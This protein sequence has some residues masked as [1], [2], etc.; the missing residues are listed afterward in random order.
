MHMNF[1]IAGQSHSFCMLLLADS[2]GKCCKKSLQA[3]TGQV[4]NLGVLN[5]QE[6]KE[7]HDYFPLGRRNFF[8]SVT[9]ASS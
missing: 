9:N 7:V 4:F 5:E 3:P 6:A 2:K 8:Q 1:Q